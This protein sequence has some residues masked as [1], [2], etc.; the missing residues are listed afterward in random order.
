VTG[1]PSS[2]A[3][4]IHTVV[5]LAAKADSETEV[6]PV[7]EKGMEMVIEKKKEPK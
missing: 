5:A 7:K 3:S 6:D 1:K 2:R 4:G